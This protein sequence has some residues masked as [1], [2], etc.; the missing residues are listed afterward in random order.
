MKLLLIQLSTNNEM[1]FQPQSKSYGLSQRSFTVDTKIDKIMSHPLSTK[2]E[3]THNKE[4]SYS[5][6]TA[7]YYIGRV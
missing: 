3:F 4:Y 6:A 2:K 5:K 1:V 7:S